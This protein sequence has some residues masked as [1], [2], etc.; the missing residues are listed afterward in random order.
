MTQAEM[1]LDYLQNHQSITQVEAVRLFGCYRLSARIYEIRE[2]GFDI[3]KTTQEAVNRFGDKV[4][5]A[6]YWLNDQGGKQ[7]GRKAVD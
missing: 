2:L 7:D 3:R 1:I 4:R 6:G 5:F